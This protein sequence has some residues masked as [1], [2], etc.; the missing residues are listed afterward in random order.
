MAKQTIFVCFTSHNIASMLL[1]V[2]QGAKEKSLNQ[3][4]VIRVFDKKNI[5]IRFTGSY[6]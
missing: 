6:V 3:K 5:Y 4:A 1:P 2:R